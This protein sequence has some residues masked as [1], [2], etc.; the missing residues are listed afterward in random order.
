MVWLHYSQF[1]T[2]C[3]FK[4]SLTQHSTS[5]QDVKQGLSIPSVVKLGTRDIKKFCD[6][7][8][9]SAC[10]AQTLYNTF[11]KLGGVKSLLFICGTEQYWLDLNRANNFWLVSKDNNF[12]IK[13]KLFD[14]SW[15]IKPKSHLPLEFCW[16]N[17]ESCFLVIA[18]IL[19]VGYFMCLKQTHKTLFS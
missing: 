19:I 5:H 10:L 18:G 13:K 15:Q 4:R 16:Q 3:V 17:L 11:L 6:S 9:I 12:F 2:L 1:N 8:Q 14:S 7:I